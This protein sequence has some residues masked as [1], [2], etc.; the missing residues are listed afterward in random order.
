[1]SG[2]HAQALHALA[3]LYAEAVCLLGVAVAPYLFLL[4]KKYRALRRDGCSPL[5][6]LQIAE[7]QLK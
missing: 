7:Q 2:Q 6:A 4:A 1:M 3:M 5:M